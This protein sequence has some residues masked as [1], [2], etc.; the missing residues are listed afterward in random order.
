[1]LEF[2]MT[3]FTASPKN[4]VAQTVLPLWRWSF[5][6]SLLE[7]SLLLPATRHGDPPG[8]TQK[9]LQR[10]M[11]FGSKRILIPTGWSVIGPTVE[12]RNPLDHHLR[13]IKPLGKQ[14]DQLSTLVQL[15]HFRWILQPGFFY[16]QNPKGSV[17]WGHQQR[18]DR[19]DQKVMVIGL[20]LVTWK[21]GVELE[22]WVHQIDLN[23]SILSKDSWFCSWW[24]HAD[25][26]V[27][28]HPWKS[29]TNI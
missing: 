10:S 2:S 29:K 1:M 17:S 3:F 12:A 16:T 13:C 24:I 6:E 22:P 18:A 27:T 19:S 15:V 7:S 26:K 4:A 5:A 23:G 28:D 14:W 8:R 9:L 21:P 11:V 25:R 20:F